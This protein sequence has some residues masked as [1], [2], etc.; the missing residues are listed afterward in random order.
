MVP[1]D[2]GAFAAAVVRVLEKPLLHQE[3]SQRGRVYARSWSSA[4]MA[5]RLR[6]LYESLR[7]APG[8]AR[9]AA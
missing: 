7:A 5:G 6:A 3:L 8:T 2:Q 1:E 4:S 9:V